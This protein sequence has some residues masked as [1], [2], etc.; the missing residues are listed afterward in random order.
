MVGKKVDG[1]TA[2][3]ADEGMGL[4]CFDGE[5]ALV[6]K[7]VKELKCLALGKGGGKELH[8]F[9]RLVHLDKGWLVAGFE[10]AD[11]EA[12]GCVHLLI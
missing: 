1:F 3:D 2:N 6:G 10:G 12:L 9:F 5:D 11:D 8:H 4:F 7:G